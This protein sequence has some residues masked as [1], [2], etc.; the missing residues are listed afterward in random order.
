VAFPEPAER[1]LPQ[2]WEMETS[3]DD[4]T[5]MIQVREFLPDRPGRGKRRS[6]Q[7][8]D[9]SEGI[10]VAGDGRRVTGFGERIGRSDGH[11]EL[12]T[13]RLQRRVLK[14][15]SLKSPY[16]PSPVPDPLLSLLQPQ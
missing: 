6:V 7:T 5:W 14:P 8:S 4:M 13:V 10:L 12:R 9:D 15:D 16:S 2:S 3:S 1:I 11:D